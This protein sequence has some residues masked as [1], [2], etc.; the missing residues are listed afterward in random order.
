MP[1][2]LS[3]CSNNSSLDNIRK[4]NSFNDKNIIREQPLPIYGKGDNIRDYFYVED[5]GKAIDLILHNGKI[6]DT[7]VIGG[8]NEQKKGKLVHHLIRIIDDGLNRPSGAH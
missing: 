8:N 1:I 2:V 6:G 5:Q 4:T 3:N 7:Y